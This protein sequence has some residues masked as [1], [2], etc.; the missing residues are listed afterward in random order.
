MIVLVA[1][2][3]WQP[4]IAQQPSLPSC[5]QT[6]ADT[7]NDPVP[8][9]RDVD[10]D[11]DGLI[12]LCSL[13]G[14]DAIRYQLDG[15]GYRASDTADRIATGCPGGS[16]RGY[17]LFRSLDFK[18]ANSYDSGNIN[19]AWTTG[20]GWLP[21]GPI[22]SNQAFIADNAFNAVFEGN[23][24]TISNFT[25]DRPD[26]NRIGLFSQINTNSKIDNIGLLNVA[27][28]GDS[29]VAS[30]VGINN[31]GDIT[32]SYA[33]GDVTGN[34]QV[35][36]LVGSSN[37]G[38]ITNSYVRGDVTG[39]SRV[40]GL[41]GFNLSANITNSYAAGA[42]IGNNQVG[43]LVGS[44]QFSN[45]TNSYATGSVTGNSR[46]GGLVSANLSSNI[47]NSYTTSDVTGN[48]QVGGLVNINDDGSITNSYATGENL[49]RLFAVNRGS[50]IDSEHL[51]IEELQSPTDDI[52]SEWSTADWDF[53]NESQLPALKYT[54]GSNNQACGIG[55][56]PSCGSLLPNQL[57]SLLDN[58]TVSS[59]GLLVPEFNPQ[60]MVY[61]VVV[62]ETVKSITLQ[63][64]ATDK[65]ITIRGNSIEEQ[66]TTAT[67]SQ[68][69]PIAADD[70]TM[71]TIEVSEADGRA[72][73]IYILTVQVAQ[74][75]PASCTRNIPDTDD[76][77][78]PAALDI[79]KDGDGLIE[80]CDFEGLNAIRHQL[81][82]SGYRASGTTTRITAGCPERG[83]RGYELVRSLDFED[84]ESYDSG[85]INTAW[86][87]GA[88]WMPIGTSDESF[89]AIF[90]GN[91]HTISNLTIDRFIDNIGLFS[92]TGANSK[93]TNIGLLNVDIKGRNN[94]GGLVGFNDGSITNSY[95]MGFMSMSGLNR[96][97]GLVGSNTGSI[98][99]SYAT[100]SMSMIGLNRMGGLVGSNTG[101]IT[102]SYATANVSAISRVG[103]L[104]G[105]NIGSI[106][107][108]Y[109]TGDVSGDSKLGGL[110]GSNTGSI[111]NSYATGRVGRFNLLGRSDRG[112]LVGENSG[113]I[114]N[115]YAS[116]IAGLN[117][118]VLV[119]ISIDDDIM[120]SQYRSIE[121]LQSPTAATDI[122]SE[123]STANWDFGNTSQLPA[124]KY[125]R[126][127]DIRNPTCDVAE[128][129]SC[130][131][132]L[133]NQL[134]NLLDNLT[135][136][137]NGLLMP[138]FDPQR[139][140]YDV[141]IGK[142]NSITL[143]AMAANKS[144]TIRSDGIEER[145]GTN[146][147][148]QNI[149]VSEDDATLI[150]IEV[151]DGRT[152]TDY[153]LTVM[154]INLP[155][156]THAIADT[157]ND[158][159]PAAIDVDKD[160]DGLIELCSLE[161]LDAIRHQLDGSGYQADSN[162]DIITMGCPE[163]DGCRGYELVRS[164][165]FEDADS[166]DSER[167]NMAWRIGDGW[168]PIGT[169]I[170]PFNAVFEGNGHTISNLMIDRFADNI[171]LFRAISRDSKITNIGL[172]NVAI[173]GNASVGGL[174]G[175][176]DGSITSS[177]AT[178]DV[179][180]RSR[181]GGS[182]GGLVGR[183]T[184]S[185]TNSYA[186]GTVTGRTAEVGGL[187]GFNRRGSITNSYASGDVTG[188][189]VVG[190]LVGSNSGR[191]TNSY[192]RGDVDGVSSVGS[193]VGN[194]SGRVTN[195]YAI[196]NVRI[197]G[198]DA[199][200]L[201]G[202]S[203][204]NNIINSQHLSIEALQAP[205][206][207]TGIYSEWDTANWDF[208][209]SAQNPALKYTRGSDVNHPACGI[210]GQPSCGDLLPNQFPSQQP[211]SD[212]SLT[213]L[214]V[215]EG[216]LIPAFMND[217]QAYTVSV[218]NQ[219]ETITV[220]PMASN[221]SATIVV[222][223]TTVNNGSASDSIPLT[224]GG[225]TI[226]TI[227][228]T[229]LD[230]TL[231]TYTI[232]VRRDFDV[233]PSCTQSIPD[234]DNDGVAA[235][236]DI[237]KDGDGLI[238]LCDLNSLDAIRYQLTG[239]GYQAN[240]TATL[241]TAGCPDN[242]CRGYELVRSL[243]FENDNSYDNGSI[244]RAWAM[245][246]G[247]LP[248]G[249][250]NRLFNAV[251]EG[252]GHTISNLII[253][254]PSMGHVG[255][256]GVI[257][258][259]SKITNLGL[260]N[261]DITGRNRVGGLAGM[262]REGSIA[263][264]YAAGDVT[265]RSDEVGS[266]VGFNN[267]RIANS[268]ASG[269]VTGNNQVGSLVGFNANRIANSYAF[270]NVTGNNQM[271]GLVGLNAGRIVNSYAFGN[272]TGNNRV[273]GLVGLNISNITNS[274][275]ASGVAA[276]GLD[277]GTLTGF[278]GGN[279]TNS[280]YQT[281]AQ[282]Q[283][284]TTA[285]GIYSKWST[286]DWDFGNA[287]QSP[288]LKYTRPACGVAGQPSCGSLLS[289]QSLSLLDNLT[290]SN[291]LL[292][293]EFNPQRLVYDVVVDENVNS[294]ALQAMAMGKSITI[295][296]DGLVE[297]VTNDAINQEILIATDG[298]TRITIEVSTADES[299]A[300][301]Y[302]LTVEVGL[303]PSCALDIPDTDDDGFSA[304]ID[305]DKDG[306]GLIELCDLEGLDAIR[307]QLEGNG[308]RVGSNIDIITTGCPERGCRGYELV[309]SLD[310]EDA[311]SYRSGRINTA[312][313]TGAGWLPIGSRDQPFNAV[314]EGNGHTISNLTIV[315][316]SISNIGLFGLIDS[317][318]KITNLG[319]LNVDNTG[320]NRVG[321]L[322]GMNRKGRIANSYVIGDVTG[323]NQ[324]GGLAGLNTGS[325]ANS[326]ATGDVTGSRDQIGSLVGLNTGSIASSYARGDVTGNNQVGSLVGINRRGSIMNSY[327][328]GNGT[329][330]NQ[331]GSLVGMNTG[332]ITNSY[333]T[334][335]TAAQ[336]P[337]AG[338]LVGSNSGNITNSMYQTIAQLQSP[339]TATDIYS[340]WSTANWD[341][342]SS[343]Q[344]PILKYA[345]GSDISN[346]TCGFSEQSSCGSLLS[347]QFI[348]FLD[349]L[350]VSNSLLVPEFNPQRLVYDVV[351]GENV[352]SIVLQAIATGKSI[353][354]DSDRLGRQATNDAIR[355][356]I[357]IA[358]GDGT[359]ITIDVSV[360]DERSAGNYL[361]TVQV[362]LLP[363]CTLDIP[364]TDGDGVSAAIDIDKDG[365][366]L[367]E[368]CDLE[369]LEAIRHQLDGSGYRAGSNMDIITTGC[370]ERGCRGYELVRSLDFADADSYDSERINTAW[371]MNAGW[372][373]IGSRDQPFN[374]VFEGNGQTISNLI[375]DRSDSSYIGL[376]GFT[377]SDS[378]IT[379]LGLL[380]VDI[381]GEN[382]VGS[383]IGWNE[384]DVT[385]SYATG[386][387]MG[388]EPVGGLVG[389]NKGNIMNSY[390]A[391]DVNGQTSVGGLVGVGDS[392]SSITNSY[393]TGEVIGSEQV[394][395]LAGLMDTAGASIMNSYATGGVMGSGDVGGL[396][397]LIILDAS[398]I[399]SYATGNVMGD[400]D[401]GG[402]VGFNG[403]SNLGEGGNEFRIDNITN[404]SPQS[405]AALQMPTTATGIYS[406]WSTANWDFGNSLQYPRLRY[407]IGSDPNNNPAC[408]TSGQ[409]D[410]G[411]LLPI[412]VMTTDSLLSSDA[413]LSALVVS[414]G[415]LSAPFDSNTR[416]Y[417]VL[418]ANTTETITVTPTATN[419]S[420]TITV[421]T[422]EAETQ[423]V[424]SGTT[425][426]AIELAAGEV[427]TIMVV[428][429]AQ[430]GNKMER[431][432]IAVSRPLSNDASLTDLTV[433]AGILTPDFNSTTLNY[434]V[435]VGNDIERLTVTPTAS[436]D[437][438]TITVEA[439]EVES[440]T[441]STTIELAAGEVTTITI[442]V[443]AQDGTPNTYTIAVTRAASPDAS[444][445]DLALTDSNGI[446]I[447]LIPN[448]A[449][450]V[451][452]YAASV[453]HTVAE[454]QVTPVASEG[455][456]ATIRIGKETVTSGD[457]ANISLGVP[458]TDTDIE[459]VVTA[460]NGTTT[461]SYTVRVSRALSDD[462]TL[463][464]L[465]LTN[466]FGENNLVRVEPF[467]E[468]TLEY[469]AEV[470][471]TVSTL[472]VTVLATDNENAEVT[473]NGSD[474][475]NGD[476][477]DIALPEAGSSTDVEIVVTA[478]NRTT[479]RT[480][481]V[482]VNRAPLPLDNDATLFD[483]VL[484]ANGEGIALDFVS[485]MTTYTVNVDH[486]VASLEVTPIANNDDVASIS[487]NGNEA[488][489]RNPIDIVLEVAGED[490]E[491]VVIVTA[492]DDSTTMSYTVTVS[493]ALSNDASLRALVLTDTEDNMIELSP[494]FA[495]MM[496]SYRA[497]VADTVGEVQVTPVATEGMMAMIRVDNE[498]VASS[499][500]VSVDLGATDTDTNIEIVVTAPDGTT[501]TYMVTVSR[502][503][504]TD[505]SLSALTVSAGTL[506]P[507]F[508]STTLNYTVS[509]AN[510]IE[511][512]TVMPTATNANA[513]IMVDDEA[514]ESGTTSTAIEL[515]EGEV[516][517]IMVVVTAQDGTENTYT[518]AVNRD[519]SAD[520]SLSDLEV[521]SGTLTPAFN[522]TTL[523]YTV[524]VENDVENLTVTPTASNENAT[525]SVDDAD[526]IS[527][528]GSDSIALTEGGTTT[529]TVV[530][531]AQD[532]SMNIYT[533]LVTRAASPDASL[534][535]L[536]LTDS[537]GITIAL[538][539]DFV[540]T[541]TSYAA[542]V[543]HTVAEVQVTPV[544]SAGMM[545]MIRIGNDTVASGDS[546]NISLGVP[547][548][549]TDIEI[550]V[551]APNGTT[552]NSYMVRVSRALSDDATL[553][554]LTLTVAGEDNLIKVEPFAEDTLEYTAEVHH[555]VSTLTVS[556]LATDNENAEITVNGSDVAS[557][558]ML[559]IA[560]P[561][562]GSSTNV[563]IVVTAQNG[564]TMRTYL[565]TVN[566]APLPLDND[567]TLFNIELMANGE[568]IALDFVSEMTTYTV[569]VAHTVA[570]LEVTPIA[571]N[572]N[573]TSITINNEDAE[574]RNPTNVPLLDPGEVT[575]IV[576]I[577]TA[578]NSSATVS[579]TV[580]VNRALSN[581]ATLSA[582]MLTS[583]EEDMIA[584]TPDFA[585]TVTNYTARVAETVTAVQVMPVATEGAMA[586]IR[587]DNDTVASSA[588][589]SVDL[590]ETGT[591]TNIEIVVTA[592]NGTTTNSYTVIV[593]RA[594]S[595]DASLSDLVV[596]EGQLDPTF[597]SD[598]RNYAVEVA[599]ATA[600]ITV[601]PTATNANATIT[602][603]A[604][605]VDNGNATDPI[606]LAEGEVTTIMVVVTAQDDTK[607]TYTIAVSRAA[608]ADASLSALTVS[609]GTLSPD[610]NST[611]LSYT[612][613][614]ANN[615][616][617][618]TVK[619]TATNVNATITV[620]DE[621]VDS[622]NAS[623]FITLAEGEVTT[624][625]VVVTA[626]DGTENTYTIA[627]SR[628]ASS[629]ASLSNLEVSP[630]ALSE[631]FDSTTLNYTVSVENDVERLTVTPTATN[632]NATITVNTV[633]VE[634]GNASKPI[635]LAAGEVTT[636]TVV[637]TAQAGNTNTYMIAVS[638]PRP[639]GIRV[640]VKVFLEG[641]LR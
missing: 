576:V 335:D 145:T 264:S 342:G 473:V 246:A 81:D 599:N 311:D 19:I 141:T 233:R 167:I 565:V 577:V 412:P 345:S 285:T 336:S 583:T 432:T 196:G 398:I 378:I 403:G 92:D 164:L 384:A 290:I 467:A 9:A 320:D 600:T 418:V 88:G 516:T 200:V 331:V 157:D 433:S 552:T 137:S 356:E 557:G 373:P 216:T 580:T 173:T 499:A 302:M 108:S 474:V 64:M 243:D 159:V 563:E 609:S 36:G 182:V 69:I 65:F 375:I 244:N 77:G 82:G 54:G 524:S 407:A 228:V 94:T 240:S 578:E 52:Y 187:V 258:L 377:G 455:M 324:V 13:E 312:W 253:D 530:V 404:S 425:S 327:A 76:D 218:A 126:G 96:I 172:L 67:I 58:L 388:N 352:N 511:Q 291:A 192:A 589:V 23:R 152:A 227:E 445:S 70:G 463:R 413:S 457:S 207:A 142:M 140:V 89:N 472:T 586:T 33:I 267:G 410:C 504:S 3:L 371:T 5:T 53:G 481:L 440:S 147:I 179:S 63:A 550:V 123:W 15:T 284:P 118:R 247:W 287:S 177:Y 570:S 14:L 479:M 529:I 538:V 217:E 636:I 631:T 103:G 328:V 232:A 277:A 229:A 554:A 459:I 47:M 286:A 252:N 470:H 224:K 453:A 297:Q 105:F 385:N 71:I 438:A 572:D 251:F 558:G 395:G 260:L 20:A 591:D 593:N 358:T 510:S 271:G 522:S 383:L 57:P 439:E 117:A 495:P 169:S 86:T 364:D 355:Q 44:H 451:T 184:G 31:G 329:G 367:I 189:G 205:T 136:S 347:N 357:L 566:R 575:E 441:T 272:V 40:G 124:L 319:L 443:T 489:N 520:A 532:R 632:A 396:V 50:I 340:E 391:G 618:L 298:G 195:S 257:G 113:T 484:M 397:G 581:N 546:A 332:S 222:N 171:G 199:R 74:L 427:T 193:L 210:A 197:A 569:N 110:V 409:P 402:L 448:F 360:P 282:L 25:I 273:G 106:K 294:I 434:T 75:S 263:S 638:R 483:L 116:G 49:S 535:D 109:A 129:P 97:G 399:N 333:A 374:A 289:N 408:G 523:N 114:M 307:H 162:M 626:Q 191:V 10:K 309:Q 624:I 231:N 130:G 158:G 42:V 51:S 119:G 610:F 587:V 533:V 514:V 501:N 368:L 35:G 468:D 161:G 201:V 466:R 178:G 337:D 24:Y 41:V 540:S 256:F 446:T 79:D 545:A 112:G 588:S 585:S 536:A 400:S 22:G 416:D 436:D 85:R 150:T 121:A 444:L 149:P 428:V 323:N 628:E 490:T 363:S 508:N 607:N 242:R 349:N 537:N 515:A 4:A 596:S 39:N 115:S 584:L 452:S 426:T 435:S 230:G 60:R 2:T 303:L 382:N 370:P 567:A 250:E 61:D 160:G 615:I 561:E 241:I 292:V 500:S 254:R 59:N 95:A 390:A 132:L 494:T 574:N 542:S 543:A 476:M 506:S 419:T 212:A 606:E 471:H 640:R 237:D 138:E 464:A 107:S 32:N 7:D 301:N 415:T 214:V 28:T 496:T 359:T 151:S 38:T 186:T 460:P 190:G 104:V 362:S 498:T 265:G 406:E 29:D 528:M 239:N 365:D 461:N 509:V 334:N 559:D 493:R 556:V 541:V 181:V 174:V 338:D 299:L 568:G 221:T 594:P 465:T 486:T 270:G 325:I 477:L 414:E 322:V 380:D 629:N 220:T 45:I 46:V 350:T 73:G 209:N 458:G 165:D 120:N 423:T 518:I 62:S 482:T 531:T 223:G 93:I 592:P 155:F 249:N 194:N 517:T 318:S 491:I 275:A 313:T 139:M 527:G 245:G 304:T 462:A 98:T 389:L 513:T 308:Y 18:D 326:Y 255:L 310:F 128:Q 469:T 386:E 198:E 560:L 280:M 547:G 447:A 163:D 424:E 83:C 30:L 314:F 475:A 183:N 248:I 8:A 91:G 306:D 156:C 544:A 625:M 203:I 175:G 56:Q 503:A 274:Y 450:T 376:F 611:T 300:G 497:S 431:Y 381:A 234:T 288:M 213:A 295:R 68:G 34:S 166:Y 454:V 526:V 262:N 72:T 84:A 102:N 429:T 341:F 597:N 153:L 188:F 101:S 411:T 238:E 148:S 564:I 598:R 26:E 99:N 620:D 641:P 562:A 16:C 555:T 502:A 354:I 266:L 135:V 261:A 590:G 603:N 27:I 80:L 394:G 276:E 48:S 401:V 442:E 421:E 612:V 278:N 635:E 519:P 379:N 372:L 478:Q 617:Q 602:V 348:S 437:N 100:G 548:T 43:G 204:N 449:T 317:N 296:S 623:G 236:I 553:S 605:A 146:D 268:Y 571:N 283:A 215:S 12:E 539:P 1:A 614:V 339:T 170:Q 417:T 143:Q 392:R 430:G 579:Y 422:A 487:I 279:I 21:I 393:A 551:T 521:S 315:K 235:A 66:S 202:A 168:M 316:S 613:S 111:T 346:L 480:Y 219:T 133:P 226:I 630:G 208:G 259:N 55:R 330:N 131:S 634:S 180:G 616:E 353:T 387:V 144:I 505:A 601:T 405:T 534:S 127:S 90:E 37:N 154:L 627:V 622:G 608:S 281:I 269:N 492:E 637:V 420:A 78:V 525:I 321:G 125:T 604:A 305:I 369:G 293:P 621:T 619:P 211:S 176:N 366:G 185:V 17:E 134:P 11:G 6:I 485:T 206:T 595:S 87:T 122:Y 549:D 639:A 456:L 344:Y 225:I 512:L 573:V 361:L 343:L 488:E 351:V 633:P 582:L 507:D